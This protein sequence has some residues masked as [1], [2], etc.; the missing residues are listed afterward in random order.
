MLKPTKF[1][2]SGVWSNH[3][4]S[5]VA[6]SHTHGLAHGLW[7]HKDS[8]PSTTTKLAFSFVMSLGSHIVKLGMRALVNTST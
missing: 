7:V 5:K 4:I 2:S 1:L 8:L 6:S 3:E